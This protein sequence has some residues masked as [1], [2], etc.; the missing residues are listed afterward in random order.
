M[1]LFRCL[2]VV[3]N[4][5][6]G[7]AVIY[8]QTRARQI[9]KPIENPYLQRCCCCVALYFPFFFIL[10][11]NILTE[12]TILPCLARTLSNYCLDGWSFWFGVSISCVNDDFTTTISA[13]RTAAKVKMRNPIRRRISLVDG[14][15]DT[16]YYVVAWWACECARAV[17]WV[18]GYASHYPT[19]L[20]TER[21]C[22]LLRQSNEIAAAGKLCSFEW[23]KWMEQTC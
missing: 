4:S 17:V 21:F 9:Q 18:Y 8:S 12:P 1:S 11:F 6:D 19:W 14:R 7:T 20:N 3:G 10:H 5:G 16:M 22:C 2:V 15:C 13:V 23:N